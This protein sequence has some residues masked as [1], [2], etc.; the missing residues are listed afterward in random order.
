MSRTYQ[1]DQETRKSAAST[2]LGLT[3][4]NRD[5][6]TVLESLDTMLE[7]PVYIENYASQFAYATGYI[8]EH[9]ADITAIQTQAQNWTGVKTFTDG[10]KFGNCPD[11]LKMYDLYGFTPAVVSADGT[12]ILVSTGNAAYCRIGSMVYFNASVEVDINSEWDRNAYIY[13]PTLP[14]PLY[15]TACFVWGAKDSGAGGGMTWSGRVSMVSMPPSGDNTPAVSVYMYNVLISNSMLGPEAIVGNR[16]LVVV[17]GCYN[18]SQT[19]V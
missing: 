16:R 18:S 8:Q 11:T 12:S 2:N 19:E 9:D 15:T 17:C 7:Q 14:T 3:G 5:M 6:K 4:A 13:M 1:Q 10:I